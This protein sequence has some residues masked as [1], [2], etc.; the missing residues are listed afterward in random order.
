M[1]KKVDWNQYMK[2]SELFN[3]LKDFIKLETVGYI[4]SNIIF[5]LIFIHLIGTVLEFINET[6]KFIILIAVFSLMLLRILLYEMSK[7]SKS[8][9]YKKLMKNHHCEEYIEKY[10]TFHNLL[11]LQIWIVI[12]IVSIGRY[13]FIHNSTKLVFVQIFLLI[14]M[15]YLA[16]IILKNNTDI[17]EL[18]KKI[19][20]RGV[21][22]DEEN[23]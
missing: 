16:K 23:R 4:L 18:E 7:K 13:I 15:I 1:S 8:I 2:N 20:K 10:N 22:K 11:L 12:S 3:E 5:S 21:F 6:Q 19:K 17:K 14:I 9:L